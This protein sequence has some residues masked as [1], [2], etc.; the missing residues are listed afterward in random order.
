MTFGLLLILEDVIRF[1]WGGLPLSADGLDEV[2][3]GARGRA[4]LG[5]ATCHQLR[6]TCLTQL[7]KAGMSLEAVQAQAGHASI[8]S[9]RGGER[10]IWTMLADGSQPHQLTTT[11]HNESPNWSTK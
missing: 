3:A 1:L 9:T 7:R 2:L 8:E 10:Q 4:G 6:H 5:H 11:G